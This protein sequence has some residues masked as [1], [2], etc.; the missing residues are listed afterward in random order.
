MA[1]GIITLSNQKY[2]MPPCWRKLMNWNWKYWV[3]ANGKCR[4]CCCL[5]VCVF[6]ATT[7]LLYDLIQILHN[8][9]RMQ[10]HTS[11]HAVQLHYPRPLFS[12]VGVLENVCYLDLNLTLWR[13]G[14][15]SLDML[16]AWEEMDCCKPVFTMYH[17]DPSCRQ[18][19]G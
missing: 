12:T 5:C 13:L 7:F 2:S 18:Q 3:G 10:K 19:R 1:I 17:T 9:V 15:K 11:F 8:A 16:Q 6:N 14:S 4:S